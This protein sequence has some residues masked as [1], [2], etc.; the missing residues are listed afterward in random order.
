[1]RARAPIRMRFPWPMLRDKSPRVP[2]VLCPS[3]TNSIC[4]YI[5]YMYMYMYI[6]IYIY[7]HTHI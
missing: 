6:Y 4:I 7:I 3:P 5:L 2:R 1:M